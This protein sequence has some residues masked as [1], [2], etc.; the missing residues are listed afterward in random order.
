MPS[1]LRSP[2]FSCLSSPPALYFSPANSQ[3]YSNDAVNGY[4]G[5]TR[6]RRERHARGVRRARKLA[7][8]NMRSK[9]SF[10]PIL[11]SVFSQ[12]YTSTV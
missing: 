12:F 11:Q 8:V 4:C 10:A 1:F 2:P 3:S 5:I 6:G 7:L 9:S